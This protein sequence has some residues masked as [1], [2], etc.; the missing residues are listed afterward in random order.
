V[1]QSTTAAIVRWNSHPSIHSR[2]NCQLTLRYLMRL[3]FRRHSRHRPGREPRCQHVGA[4]GEN[5]VPYLVAGSL[6]RF[7]QHP[8]PV[9]VRRSGSSLHEFKSRPHTVQYGMYNTA[10]VWAECCCRW[11]LRPLR[12]CFGAATAAL[13]FM[14][15]PRGRSSTAMTVVH[16]RQY[17]SSVA[18]YRRRLICLIGLAEDRV[19]SRARS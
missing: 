11:S 2:N 19:P 6:T 15:S 17:L 18:R 9:G 8:T 1:L 13:L 4:A 12:L 3:R 7:S 10:E 16:R 5:R 14:T